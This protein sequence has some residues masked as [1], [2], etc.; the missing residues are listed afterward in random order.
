MNNFPRVTT[1]EQILRDSTNRL[2]E[3]AFETGAVVGVVHDGPCFHVLQGEKRGADYLAWYF[4][5][6][7][8]FLSLS[9]YYYRRFLYVRGTV[10]AFKVRLRC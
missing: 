2:E 1:E 9:E 5:I 7:K 3:D 8:A 6:T 4:S 10:R